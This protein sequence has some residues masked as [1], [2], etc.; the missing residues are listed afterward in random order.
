MTVR[1]V[2]RIGLCILAATSGFVG[3]WALPAPRA[4]YDG[5]PSAGHAWVALLP[6]YNEHLIRDVGAFSLALTVMLGAAAVWPERRLVRIALVTTAVFA[7]PHA[8]F[9]ATHLAGFPPADAAAQTAGIMGQI[10]LMLG[11]F[12]LT[13]RLPGRRADEVTPGARSGGHTHAPGRGGGAT[14]SSGR[15]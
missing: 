2:L 4:F 9:Q 10:L 11:L 3:V 13:W 14:A 6:P 12:A 5:F 7:V 1:G 15:G 8:V